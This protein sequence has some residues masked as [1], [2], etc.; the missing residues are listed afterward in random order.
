[1]AIINAPQLN[2]IDNV[3]TAH[4]HE[5]AKPIVPGAVYNNYTLDVVSPTGPAYKQ[6]ETAELL[7][8]PEAGNEEDDVSMIES[9]TSEASE[10]EEAETT[11][12][13]LEEQLDQLP[14]RSTP[15][16]PKEFQELVSESQPSFEVA[17]KP[18]YEELKMRRKRNQAVTATVAGAVGLVALGPFGVF[19]GA[20]AGAAIS[21]QVGKSKERN[22]FRGYEQRTLHLNQVPA[23]HGELV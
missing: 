18:V 7:I 11:K 3:A 2:G 13:T 8:L 16:A 17:S 12:Q 5:I 19:F 21:K 6:L 15:V 22:I 20:V 1:M 9:E 10:E 14:K 4:T 23:R